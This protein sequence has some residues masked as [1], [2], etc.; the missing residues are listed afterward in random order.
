MRADELPDPR[1]RDHCLKAQ[2]RNRAVTYT[3]RNRMKVVDFT[4]PCTNE[5]CGNRV[6]LAGEFCW[7]CQENE[8]EP[9][10]DMGDGG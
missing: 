4:E 5:S 6:R 8:V 3:H 10:V 2:N 1:D 7:E 9:V